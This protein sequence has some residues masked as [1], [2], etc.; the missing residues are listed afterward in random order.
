MLL[1]WV[2]RNFTETWASECEAAF[3]TMQPSCFIGVQDNALAGFA[4]Y[5]CTRKN[6]FG[7]T[8]VVE[9]ARGKGV[10]LALLLACLHAMRDDGYAYA[11]IGGVGP[12]EYY[13]KAVGATLIEGSSPG[14]YDFGLIRKDLS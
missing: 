8:G 2:R 5:D 14:I 6:F 10:G 13:A 12:T 9:T 11:I 4:C 1:D 3:A 7:P